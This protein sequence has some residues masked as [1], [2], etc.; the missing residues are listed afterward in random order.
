MS[1]YLKIIRPPNLII[2]AVLQ[3]ILYYGILLPVF[4]AY[5]LKPVLSSL[6][7]ILFIITTIIITASGYVINDIIDK[8]IDKVN[9]KEKLIVI[10]RI[11]LQNAKKYYISLIFAGGIISLTIAIHIKEIYYMLFYFAAVLLLYLYSAYF[12][13]KPLWGNITVSF[14]SAMVLGIIPVF[15]LS[16]IEQLSSISYSA[17]LHINYI[18]SGFMVFSFLVSMYRELVK[19][20]EDMEGD[21]MNNALTFPVIYGMEPAKLLSGI[22]SILILSGL[23]YWLKMDF[24]AGKIYMK[25]YTIIFV[26]L[27][28]FYSVYLLKKAQVKPDFHRLSGVIKVIIAMGI[29]ILF[30]YI[31]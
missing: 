26:M 10:N 8:D 24:N 17:Y 27:P 15:E 14:F 31:Q 6:Y 4:K 13:K 9:K 20:I 1:S 28:L 16:V 21:K 12:K 29:S 5:G 25:F 3:S 22:I 19:D 11:S 7:F 2:I 30:F 18:F 23:F